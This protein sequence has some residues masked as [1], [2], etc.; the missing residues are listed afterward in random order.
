MRIENRDDPIG[1]PKMTL[2]LGDND[3]LIVVL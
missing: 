1:I 3:L 2:R